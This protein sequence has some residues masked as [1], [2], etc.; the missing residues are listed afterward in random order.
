MAKKVKILNCRCKG[1]SKKGARNC[2]CYDANGNLVVEAN[3]I[4]FTKVK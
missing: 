1:V 4:L 2:M 3:V